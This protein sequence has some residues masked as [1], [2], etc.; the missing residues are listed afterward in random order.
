[1]N[2]PIFI[3][4]C[5]RSGTT[6]TLNI[7][8]RHEELAW[9][10]DKLNV[11]PLRL[12]FTRLNGIYDLPLVGNSLY[13]AATQGAR[14]VRLP[15]RVINLLPTPVEPWHFWNSY[16]QNFQWERGGSV[17]PR[18][19][20]KEDI[21]ASE[22]LQIRQ[23]VKSICE[24]QKKRRFLSKYTDFPRI[25]YLNEAFSDALFI[26]I[27]RDG[28]AVAASYLKEIENGRFGTWDERE[29]WIKGWPTTWQDEWEKEYKTPLSFVAFQWKFFISEIWADKKTISK[30]R[31][32]EL[33]YKD[34]VTNPHSTFDRLFEF[35]DLKKSKRVA[36]YL[37][38]LNL[39]N[40]DQKWKKRFND[41]EKETLFKIV[42]DTKFK[43][44]LDDNV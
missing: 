18:R 21:S 12:D 24:Y 44:L 19:R 38:A 10:N 39:G 31:Y 22:I 26:H 32:M 16:L 13:I 6:L 40:M 9:I 35:C 17:L 7:V 4:G 27:I 8:A 23:T 11:N 1:V 15:S 2:K 28:R 33:Y 34:I 5:P 42:G 25:T 30:S 43:H 20:T 37:D 29:W 41:E 14:S 36:S 3:I